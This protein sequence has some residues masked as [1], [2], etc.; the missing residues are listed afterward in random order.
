MV[1]RLSS[2][3]EKRIVR[4]AKVRGIRPNRLV[5][6]I[7]KQHLRVRP[8]SRKE[9][10]S[11]TRLQLDDLLRYKKRSAN[12]MTA[13]RQA[14]QEAGRRYEDNVDWIERAWTQETGNA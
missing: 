2:T 12:F 13:V 5:E 14:K 4:E 9:T 6:N 10:T 7:L 1:I 8:L 11:A 3:L